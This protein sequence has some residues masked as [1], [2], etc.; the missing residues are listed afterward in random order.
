MRLKRTKLYFA[1][2]FHLG[3]P[4]Y[5]RSLIREKL[6][7]SWLTEVSKDAAEIF[8]MGD[9]FDFWFEYSTVVPK[10]F[11]RLLGKIAEIT[12]QGIPVH[13]FRGNHDVWAFDYLTKELNVHLYRNPVVREFGGS[14]FYLAHGDGLGPGDHGYKFLKK[15]FE[16]K[17]NQFLFKWMHPDI[18][19]RLGLYFSGRSRLANVAKAGKF[20]NVPEQQK[21]I[22]VQFAKDQ[23]IDFPDVNFFIFGHRH[24]PV[25]EKIGED[26]S[27]VI[28][29]D[30]ITHFTYAVFDQGNMQLLTYDH[31]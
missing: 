24:V 21:Q 23:L 6:L 19:T 22:L 4:D 7:V 18:G 17:P 3:I 26:T 11:V 14:T 28:L 15:V 29:G 12:D 25:L 2:D 8:L 31:E 9:I 16:F 13:V 27:L 30:W 20:E 10:G 1:S 5:S